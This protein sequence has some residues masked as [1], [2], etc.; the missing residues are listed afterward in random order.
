MLVRR[1][2]SLA[3]HWQ[4]LPSFPPGR[5]APVPCVPEGTHPH[6]LQ[7][8]ANLMKLPGACGRGWVRAP[9]PQLHTWFLGA[10]WARA[11]QGGCAQ[12]CPVQLSHHQ[13]LPAPARRVRIQPEPGTSWFELDRPGDSSFCPCPQLDYHSWVPGLCPA[14][15]RALFPPHIRI[16]PRFHQPWGATAMVPQRLAHPQC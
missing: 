5:V 13:L 9:V 11:G 6:G 12:P 7:A 4:T 16:S 3:W 10:A 1:R 15:P 8:S 2:G 14:M